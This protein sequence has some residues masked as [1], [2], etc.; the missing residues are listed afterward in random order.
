MDEKKSE[1]KIKIIK[2]GPYI[3]TGNVPLQES[4]ITP[5]GKAYEYQPGRELPQAE[6]YA[7]CRCG[8]S[9]NPPFC[10]GSHVDC[11]FDGTETASRDRFEDR[12]ELFKGPELD[13]LDDNRCAFARFCHSEKGNVWQLIEES[14]KEGFR[15][16]AIKT[17]VE[18]PAGRLQVMDKTGKVIEPEYEP[19][20]EILQDPERRV[21][22]GIF[23]KGM[24][25]LE[26]EDGYIYELRN[27]Y[28]LCR[29]GKSRKKPFCDATHVPMKYKDEQ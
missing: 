1:C 2:D 29:C 20:I 24:I 27:R 13:L 3:V 5:K 25:P 8:K 11:N 12:A 10:D 15:E 22:G 21:S 9:K 28:V 18:C 4:I 14:D 19:S 7:L 16:L 23:V 6:T 26:S 17:A